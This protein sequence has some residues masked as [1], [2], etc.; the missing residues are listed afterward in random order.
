MLVL[1]ASYSEFNRMN[2]LYYTLPKYDRT[3]IRLKFLDVWVRTRG[4]PCCT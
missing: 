4:R 2:L 1:E 3:R